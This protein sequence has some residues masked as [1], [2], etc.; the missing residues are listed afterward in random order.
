[1]LGDDR[2]TSNEPKNTIEP[3]STSTAIA[4]WAPRMLSESGAPI[5]GSDPRGRR[6]VTEAAVPAGAA[7]ALREGLDLW[8]G[9]PL[10]DVQVCMSLEAEAARRM[11]HH[12]AVGRTP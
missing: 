6:I 3:V 12:R 7:E 5:E 1:M 10:A 9:E 2:C 11:P 8:R 4:L